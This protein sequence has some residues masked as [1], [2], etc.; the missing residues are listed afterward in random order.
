MGEMFELGTEEKEMHFEVGKYA[1]EQKV[2][3]LVCIGPLSAETVRGAR[4]AAGDGM[5]IYYFSSKENFLA[6]MNKILQSGDTILVKASHGME[7]SKIVE[8]LQNE[9]IKS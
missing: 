8:R 9:G 7:F 2:S 5:K 1:A 3:V 6:D 4:A